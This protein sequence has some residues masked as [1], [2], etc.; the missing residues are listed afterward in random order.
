M[1]LKA[2][3]NYTIEAV[4]EECGFQSRQTFHRLF[5]DRYGMTPAEYRKT[6]R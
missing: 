4:A 6:I 2:K 1:L 3:G 5:I